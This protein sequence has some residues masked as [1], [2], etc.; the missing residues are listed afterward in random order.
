MKIFLSGLGWLFAKCPECIV[1]LLCWI[2]GAIIYYFPF[3]RISLA[4]SNIAR[5]LPNIP[6]AERKKIAF[7][8]A[9]RM[10]EMALF[11]LASP[12]MPIEN[13]RQRV[14]VSENLL[15]ELADLSENPRPMVLMIPH[16]AM[17]ETITMFPILVDKKLPRTGV[18]YRPFDIQGMEDWVKSSRQRFGID[19]LSRKKGLFQAISYLRDNGCVAV[20]FDQKVY[21]G[22]RSFLLDR[23]CMT[24][25][26][27]GIL[28]ENS[29]A[30]AAT[31][32]ATRTGFWRSRIDCKKFTGTT[33]E[34][35]TFEGNQW[36]SEKL[37]TDKIAQC[38]W[39]WLHRRWQH[40]D[41]LSN[42]L[43]LKDRKNILQFSL[44]KMGLTEFPR[45]F[46]IYITMPDSDSESLAILP[47]IKLMRQSRPDANVS[48][49]VQKKN[50]QI[51]REKNIADNIIELPNREDGAFARISA[52][53][54]LRESYPE[55]HFNFCDSLLDDICSRILKADFSLAIQTSRKRLFVKDVYKA[56]QSTENIAD[57]YEAFL[58]KYGL[59]GELEK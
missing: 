8:S 21:S 30:N 34:E 44:E 42:L 55:V 12:H 28:V 45:T 20:L 33:I 1:N 5:S 14:E 40:I 7:E 32:W 37:R 6:S 57:V 23:I 13:L 52:Y 41:G 56:S 24:S 18:F 50:A 9:R 46:R 17:M 35:I 11:V 27:A 51:L 22:M 26:L 36:L 25:E 58:R 38:D 53:K 59:K 31:F 2:V 16:F 49:L 29:N 47:Y 10:V 15:K 19:L 4:L 3:G 48:L 39:L 43:C 54:R